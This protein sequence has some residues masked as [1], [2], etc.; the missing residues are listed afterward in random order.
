MATGF[1]HYDDIPVGNT[2]A[3]S[4]MVAKDMEQ[5]MNSTDPFGLKRRPSVVLSRQSV[6]GCALC[7]KSDALHLRPKD[8]LTCLPMEVPSLQA[9][10]C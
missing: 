1:D 4:L 9:T 5:I 2:K 10:P 6:S 7:F 8:T 3:Q